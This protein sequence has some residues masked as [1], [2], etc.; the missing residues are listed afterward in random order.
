MGL[1]TTTILLWAGAGA[2]VGLALFLALSA[3]L[4]ALRVD[5]GH[6]TAAVFSIMVTAAV[7]TIPIF[8][9]P[10]GSGSSSSDPTRDFR[11][12]FNRVPPARVKILDSESS[13]ENGSTRSKVLM[14]ISEDDLQDLVTNWDPGKII[15]EKLPSDQDLFLPKDCD[16]QLAYLNQPWS[17]DGNQEYSAVLY[18]VDTSEAIAVYEKRD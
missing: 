1:S 18:C 5:S 12:I 16:E 3:V 11:L 6:F 9:P 17:Q 2:A 15:D 4:N 8:F 7:T 13:T 10:A 14:R